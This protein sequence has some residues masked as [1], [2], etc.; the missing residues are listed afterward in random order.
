MPPFEQENTQPGGRRDLFVSLFFVGLAGVLMMLPPESQEQISA[1]LRSSV[2]APFIWTQE[3]LHEA[4]ARTVEVSS[5]QARMDSLVAEGS[6]RHTLEEENRR[7]RELLDLS[8]RGG[9]GFVAATAV[10]PGTRGSESM[11]LLD[12]GSRSGVAVHDPVVTAQGL[13]GV[14]RGVGPR[15]S[16]AMD[17]T[18]PDF[19]ASVMTVDGAAY[20]IVEPSHGAFREEDRLL[21]TGVPYHTPLAEGI[22]VVTSGMGTVYPRGILVGQVETVAETEAGWRRSYWVRPSVRPG[23][24]TH[25]LVLAAG[26]ER[27]PA[28]TDL[29]R[30]WS[31]PEGRP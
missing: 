16:L 21:L 25:A 7:L 14:V 28:E 4:R 1:A 24:V 13:V 30:L 11:F 5:L 6:A 23:S 20:G 9:A 18:H 26:V 2:L 29:Q 3:S 15:S 31:G 22:R 12:V 27:A 8:E 10:R 19:R 17:W